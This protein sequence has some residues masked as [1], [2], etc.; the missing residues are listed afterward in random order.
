MTVVL[1]CLMDVHFFLMEEGGAPLTVFEG[2]GQF[3]F[4]FP[5]LLLM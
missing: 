4:P 3:T 1:P 5:P 2:H